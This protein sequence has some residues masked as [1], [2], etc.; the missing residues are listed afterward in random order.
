MKGGT[1]SPWWLKR[2]AVLGELGLSDV[3]ADRRRYAERMRERAREEENGEA[4]EGDWC[5]G[6]QAFRKRM[7]ALLDRM[8]DKLRAG[9]EVDRTVRQSHGEERAEA[10]LQRGLERLGLSREELA[11][12]RKN[13]ERKIAIGRVIRD[14]T[15]L[16]NRWIAE[17]VSLGH[18]SRVSRYCS[19]QLDSAQI[20]SLVERILSD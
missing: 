14:Q 9:K 2:G 8:N 17:R 7:L 10:L 19:G 11:A 15:T 1:I 6:G 20:G 12:L 4:Q 5:L 16:S 18:V 3:S 13:G